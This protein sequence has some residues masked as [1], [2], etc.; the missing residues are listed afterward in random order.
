MP[1]L[2][3]DLRMKNLRST[4]VILLYYLLTYLLYDSK[5]IRLFHSI[6]K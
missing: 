4:F 6:D 1:M 3:C 5:V 2:E